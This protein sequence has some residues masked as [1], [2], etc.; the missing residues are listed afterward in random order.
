MRFL[1]LGPLAVEL[2]GLPRTLGGRRVEAVAAALLVH[3]GAPM[4]A[5]ALVDAVWGAGDRPPAP[6]VRWTR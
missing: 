2:D 1:D 3:V 5:A 6:A 4:P